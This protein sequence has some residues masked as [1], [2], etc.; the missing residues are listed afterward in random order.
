M[1]DTE[2]SKLKREQNYISINWTKEGE[3]RERGREDGME[4][5]SVANTWDKEIATAE[6][7]VKQQ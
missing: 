2:D 7:N 4:K 5:V 3:K 6:N 1:I